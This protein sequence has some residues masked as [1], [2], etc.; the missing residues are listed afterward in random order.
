MKTLSSVAAND[1]SMLVTAVAG[2]LGRFTGA[3]R[4]HAGSDLAVYLS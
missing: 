3:S 1:R 2:Y 4:V